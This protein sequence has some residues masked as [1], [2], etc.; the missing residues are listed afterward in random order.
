MFCTYDGS[1]V[2]FRTPSLRLCAFEQKRGPISVLP[3]SLL[4]R[5][6]AVKWDR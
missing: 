1:R 4:K 2:H 6:L 5:L 3:L